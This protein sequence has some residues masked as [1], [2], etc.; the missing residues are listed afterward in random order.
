[1]PRP[2]PILILLRLTVCPPCLRWAE[3]TGLVETGNTVLL[4]VSIIGTTKVLLSL[5]AISLASFLIGAFV[6]GHV[7]L[8][9]GKCTIH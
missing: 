1:M 8:A 4:T 9:F 5:T 2:M 3:R 7:G 6:F